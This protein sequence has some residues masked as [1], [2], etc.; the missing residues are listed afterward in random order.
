MNYQENLENLLQMIKYKSK[1][2]KVILKFNNE[3]KFFPFQTREP[4][5]PKFD[6]GFKKIVSEFSRT[7][8]NLTM[9]EEFTTN[10]LFTQTL[11]NEKIECRDEEDKKYLEA[12]LKDYLI[13]SDNE[14]N[15]VHPYLY[16]YVSPTHNLSNSGEKAIAQFFTD[17]FF[18]DVPEFKDYFNKKD[19][20]EYSQYNVL[21]NMIIDSLPE[22]Q[23]KEYGTKYIPKLDYITEVFE[24]DMLFA[25][26]NKDFLNKNIENIFAYY[27]FY[28]ITQLSLKLFDK[29]YTLDQCEEVYCLLE[30]ESGS[31]NRKSYTNGY[32]KIKDKTSSLLYKVYTIDYINKLLATK[33]LVFAELIDYFAKLDDEEQKEFLR[34]FREFIK[35]YSKTLN[36]E[37]EKIMDINELN[38]EEL[39]EKLY[40]TF[41]EIS[42]QSPSS[43]YS[44][45]FDEL[46]KKY[47]LKHRGPL[48]YLLN[49]S[50]EM[51]L[52]ITSLCIKEDKIALKDL[53]KEYEKRGIFFDNSSKSEV[54][55]LLTK[56]NYID[57]KSDSGEAQYV[58]RIL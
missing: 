42:D 25:L 44:K 32:K 53:F 2:N 24:N 47:F 19:E 1:E 23:E 56:L 4:E 49:M 48:G 13:D 46:G 38:F 31:R 16:K 55:N 12:L 11:S 51:L 57:K 26:E 39:F 18:R 33:G 36:I 15:V 34:V 40:E 58:R 7:I 5:R 50:Q 10:I 43:R 17:V 41:L 9:D 22:L 54:E 27:Y 28:Y 3:Y 8:N 29:E 14:L 52:T 35:I 37:E 30:S 21:I 20:E 6:L 45:I